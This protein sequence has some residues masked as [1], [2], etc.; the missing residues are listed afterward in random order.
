MTAARIKTSAG[1]E[2]VIEQAILDPR[3]RQIFPRADAIRNC[4]LYQRHGRVDVLLLPKMGPKLVLIEAITSDSPDVASKV[5][6]QLMMYYSAALQLGEKGLAS[7]R[8]CAREYSER[9]K[10]INKRAGIQ[11]LESTMTT[12][13]TWH[14]LSRG[15][16]LRPEEIRLYVATDGEPD[17]AVEATLLA[18]RKHH[19]I[20]IGLIQ[21]VNQVVT[22]CEK[23]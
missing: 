12:A 1:R 16:K 5:I 6:G 4:P 20:Q 18:L 10:S 17:G 22:V 15:R 8:T 14:K 21:V 23:K 13:E 11:Y 7:L 19:G 9:I 3:A 2:R